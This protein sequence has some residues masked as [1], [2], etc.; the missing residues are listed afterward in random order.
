MNEN[1]IKSFIKRTGCVMRSKVCTNYLML[2]TSTA[3]VC[4]CIEREDASFFLYLTSV[5]LDLIC[6]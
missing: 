4:I 6:F 2:Y 1:K 5:V 3:S